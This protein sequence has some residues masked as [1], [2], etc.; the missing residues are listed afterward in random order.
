LIVWDAWTG[1]RVAELHSKPRWSSLAWSPDGAWIAAGV[2]GSTG[3]VDLIDANRLVASGTLE[4]GA[5][6]VTSLDFAPDS[7]RLATATASTGLRVLDLR[8]RAVLVERSGMPRIQSV[9]WSADGRLLAI[10]GDKGWLLIADG[11]QLES[12]RVLSAHPREVFCAAFSRDG[13]RLFSAGR[14]GQLLVWDVASGDLVGQFT[15]HKDYIWSLDTSP[16]GTRVVTGSGDFTVRQWESQS[17][18][19]T[20]ARRE[21]AESLESEARPL[22]QRRLAELGDPALVASCL[23]SD[24]GLTPALREAAL[25]ELLRQSAAHTLLETSNR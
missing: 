23:R 21:Q 3:R 16:D 12:A 11:A 4:A 2:D 22:V 8:S 15:G 9:R 20:V 10:A 18:R 19:E 6:P 7:A 24:S 17:V 1:A 25:L 5:G 13:S 14:D